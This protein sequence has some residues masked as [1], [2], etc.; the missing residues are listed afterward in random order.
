MSLFSSAD[1][2][3]SVTTT[4][5]VLYS[6]GTRFTTTAAGVITSVRFCKATNE[7]GVG[8]AAKIYDWTT[9]NLL[10]SVSFID[11]SCT[12]PSFVTITLPNPVSTTKG[13]SYLVAVDGLKYYCKTDN[14]FTTARTSGALTS[15]GGGTYSLTSGLI[16]LDGNTGKSNYFIDGASTR[17]LLLAPCSVLT[18][19]H[20]PPLS[21]LSCCLWWLHAVEFYS[22]TG[23]PTAAPVSKPTAPPTPLPTPAPTNA[24]IASSVACNTWP[25]VSV[26]QT[27]FTSSDRPTLTNDGDGTPYSLGVIFTVDVAGS[28]TGFRYFKGTAE[29]AATHTGKIYDWNTMALLATTGAFNDKSCGGGQWVSATLSTPLQVSPGVQYVAAIDSI[30][31]FGK[32]FDYLVSDKTNNDLTAQGYGALYGSAGFMPEETFWATANYWVDG[33]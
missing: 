6:L 11:I 14:F 16:P 22:G 25:P 24:A 5:N 17:R 28:I 10:S 31:S 1:V 7:P 9:G 2:P 19:P 12:G 8:H 3:A 13:G 20:S 27:I 26:A 29:T 32:S 23:P 4:D 33:K 21:C 15:Q 18:Q 30:T